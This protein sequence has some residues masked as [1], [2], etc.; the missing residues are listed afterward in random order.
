[1]STHQIHIFISHSWAHSGHYDTLASWIFS[2]NWSVGQASLDFRDYSVPKNDPIHDANNDAELRAKIFAQIARSHIIVMPSGLYATHS[3]WIGKEIDGAQ[4]Y[5][6]R[7]IAVDLWGAQRT[8]TVVS[9]A[10]AETVGWNSQ[11][12]IDAIW[13]HYRS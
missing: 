2:E 12:V 11:S 8:S 6:K 5:D 13:R 3:K 9:G 7:I 4:L 10:A 1:M